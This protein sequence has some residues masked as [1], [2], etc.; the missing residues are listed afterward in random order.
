MD[1][2]DFLGEKIQKAYGTN[3]KFTEVLRKNGIEKT[4][5]AVKKWRQ[6]NSVPKVGELKAIS[7]TLGIEIQE[8]FERPISNDTIES[9]NKGYN[10][11]KLQFLIKEA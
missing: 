9:K 2:G 11:K 1:L 4:E 7:R 8:L 5:D 3:A 10:M 6:G